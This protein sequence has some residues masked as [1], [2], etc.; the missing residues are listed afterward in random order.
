MTDKIHLGRKGDTMFNIPKGSTI[1]A[2]ANLHLAIYENILK[3]KGN[4]LDITVSTFT[5]FMDSFF[6]IPKEK[7]LEILYQYQNQL[8]K[9]N[10]DNAFFT[11]MYDSQFLRSLYDF[12]KWAKSYDYNFEDCPQETQKEKDLYQVVQLVK[13]IPLPCQQTQTIFKENKDFSNIYILQTQFSDV[14]KLW[15]DYLLKNGAHI[16]T[17]KE[18]THLHYWSCANPR[19]QAMLVAQTIFDKK[20]NADDIQIALSSESD[21]QIISQIFDMY[22]IPYTVL[23]ESIPSP[24]I[25]KCIVCL[26]WIQEKS[27]ENFLNLVSVLYGKTKVIEYFTL[28]PHAFDNKTSIQD[29]EYQKNELISEFDFEHYQKVEAYTQEWLKKKSYIFNWEL[30]DF[31]AILDEIKLVMPKLSETDYAVLTKM[32]TAF[33]IAKP[34]IHQPQDLNLV[35]D[36]L[37]NGQIQVSPSTNQGALITKRNKVTPLRKIT[38]FLSMTNQEF[39]VLQL[40][41]GIFNEA[42]IS[43]TTLPSLQERIEFQNKQLFE[44]LSY[45]SEVYV[46]LPQSAFDS[47]GLEPSIQLENYMKEKGIQNEFKA[48]E[49]HSILKKPVLA[50]SSDVAKELFVKDNKFKGSVSRLEKFARCPFS[51]F[52]NY[53]LYLREVKNFGD[54]SIRGSIFHHILETIATKHKKDYANI[55]RKELHEIISNEFAFMRQIFPNQIKWIHSQIEE[56]EEKLNLILI[57]LSNFEKQWR[58]KID[59]Q[60]YNF[61]YSYPWDDI[62]IELYGF[63]DR[64]D[65]SDNSFCIFDYKS[66]DKELK[67]DDFYNGTSLQLITY[68]LAYENESGLSPAGNFYIALKAQPESQNA[69]KVSY[70]KKFPELEEITEK[71]TKEAFDDS[72][73]LK[74]WSYHEIT[75]FSDNKKYFSIPKKALNLKDVKKAHKV[76]MNNLLEDI[77]S[78]NIT[79]DHQKDACKYCQ[80]EMICRN[81][82]NEISKTNRT[83][84]EEE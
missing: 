27:L 59:Q 11:S 63:I 17:N 37:T 31:E 73:R 9:L 57:Q 21:Q 8:K 80:Y 3:E 26:Q 61:S 22:A 30:N 79:A 13:D 14:E 16:L 28:F 60:E 19:T 67:L 41:T 54:V 78:G 76:I 47:K 42:Y 64:I 75:T 52:V 55:D 49:E 81:A 53:G 7:P 10:T 58:M 5:T 24:L 1:I 65:R 68:T 62:T 56:I 66:S 50:I 33:T 40:Q 84:T 72:K 38:F 15:V 34:Y 48:I 29:I 23:S 43:K 44:S 77:F 45:S 18:E 36:T 25:Q 71:Q 4:T 74:G 83:E 20:L 51:H 6:K 32:I 69:L 39:P 46:L 70:S 82:K 35:I 2:D 12:I